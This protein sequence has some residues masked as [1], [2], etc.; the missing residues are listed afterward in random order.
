[1]HLN[2]CYGDAKVRDWPETAKPTRWLWRLSREGADPGIWEGVGGGVAPMRTPKA[3]KKLK[4]IC[5]PKVRKK[6]NQSAK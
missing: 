3:R 2:V 1:M 5:A 4:A 6:E